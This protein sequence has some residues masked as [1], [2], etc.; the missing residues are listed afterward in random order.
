VAIGRVLARAGVSSKLR[1]AA[2]ISGSWDVQTEM[3]AQQIRALRRPVANFYL[4]ASAQS[5]RQRTEAGIQAY[6]QAQAGKPPRRRGCP[7]PRAHTSATGHHAP[8][9]MQR[10]R[11]DGK[12]WRR[13]GNIISGTST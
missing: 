10:M 1:R 4:S 11:W 8:T 12:I 3:G 5:V 7:A 9:R 2:N 13:F 6:S